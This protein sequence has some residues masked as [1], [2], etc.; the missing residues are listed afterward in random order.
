[1]ARAVV[2]AAAVTVLAALRNYRDLSSII[3][4]PRSVLFTV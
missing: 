1:M 3:L 4:L 2:I